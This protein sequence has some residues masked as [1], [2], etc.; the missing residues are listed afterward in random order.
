MCGEQGQRRMNHKQIDVAEIENL[1]KEKA[2]YGLGTLWVLR[3]YQRTKV[4]QALG[5]GPFR[6]SRELTVQMLLC[7]HIPARLCSD[8]ALRRAL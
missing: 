3:A 4:T 8:D 7:E 2:S 6:E 5:L 1:R